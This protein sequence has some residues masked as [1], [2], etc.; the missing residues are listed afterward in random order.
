MNHVRILAGMIIAA[1]L[2]MPQVTAQTTNVADWFGG[3]TM[4]GNASPDGALIFSFINGS[5]TAHSNATLG[6][7]TLG[8]Y[9]IHVAA[10]AGANITFKVFDLPAYPTNNSPQLW[11]VIGNSSSLNLTVNPYANGVACTY[12]G[13]CNSTYC[14]DGYCCNTA[15]TTSGYDCNVA[16][17]IGTCTSTG[18]GTGGGTGGSTG[19]GGT[20]SSSE[21]EEEEPA[22]VEQPVT[23]SKTVNKISAGTP[24]KIVFDTAGLFMKGIRIETTGTASNVMI[25]VSTQSGLPTTVGTAPPATAVTP[26]GATVSQL[27]F[28]Y[29]T[30][31]LT[32]IENM[33]KH[34]SIDFEVTKLWIMESNIDKDAITLLR[35]SGGEWQ[36]LATTF[37]GETATGYQ[38]EAETPGFSTFAVVGEQAAAATTVCTPGAVQCSSG[39]RQQCATDGMSWTVIETCPNG[40]DG[41]Q[42]AAVPAGWDPL[43]LGG[44]VGI[45]LLVLIVI[46]LGGFWATKRK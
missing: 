12:G 40:C 1:A 14:V 26:S 42:C 38:F 34:A 16:G 7:L 18:G 24:Q 36:T 32:N 8:W 37:T 44:I 31:D 11:T 20:T 23:A 28:K 29:I 10:G 6:K 3:I 13:S 19:S 2:L 45:I 15:C 46:G 27:V 39:S 43:L 30:I 35:Y 22:P 17:T 21:E 9:L 4:T 25:S 41:N 33:L 5:S